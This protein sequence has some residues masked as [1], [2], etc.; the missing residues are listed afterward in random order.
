MNPALFTGLGAFLFFSGLPLFLLVA[1]LGLV[2]LL[3]HGMMPQALA[4]K[5]LH[6]F[7]NPT[8]LCIPCF[9]FQGVLITESVSGQTVTALVVRL[10]GRVR[11]GVGAASVLTC[12]FFSALSGSSPSALV[13]AGGMLRP[14]LL[15]GGM[16]DRRAVGLLTVAG[17][18]GVLLPPSVPVILY[19]VVAR[20]DP[21]DMFQ[22]CAVAAVGLLVMFSVMGMIYG[23]GKPAPG[24]LPVE[25]P[26]MIAA[27]NTPLPWLLLKTIPVLMLPVGTLGLVA[28]GWA[29]VQA[30]SALGV[31]YV[32]L[33]EALLFRTLLAKGGLTLLGRS[34]QRAASMTAA[35]LFIVAMGGAL[36]L[37]TTELQIAE[38][39]T[40][41]L[42]THFKS[43]WS[44]LLA[45]N[46]LF[47]VAGGLMDI[48]ASLLLFVP[49]LLPAAESLGL[50]MVHLGVVIL[51]NLEAGFVTP[52]FALNLFAASTFFDLPLVEVARRC[53][54]FLL[55]MLVWLLVLTFVPGLVTWVM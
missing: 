22:G 23:R 39:V 7:D 3:Q 33:I 17:S 19:G 54:P 20:Q 14:A 11:G 41:F 12:G 29:T 27:T 4:L 30:A 51:L 52:P 25:T 37:L 31:F 49:L 50:N 53:G 9:I 35:I 40:L 46:V 44:F 2:L 45:V 42:T 15:K 28:M 55:A 13:A 43:Q 5:F 18:L 21:V 16:D 26:Q 48:Y 24:P 10:L 8:L 6:T 47:L 34:L 36:N 38:Q 32:L 1:L